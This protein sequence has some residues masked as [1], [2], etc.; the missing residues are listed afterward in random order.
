MIPRFSSIKDPQRVRDLR[1]EASAAKSNAF[2]QSLGE[3]TTKS[4]VVKRMS[5]EAGKATGGATLSILAYLADKPKEEY[6]FGDVTKRVIRSATGGSREKTNKP[7]L[8]A[9]L[10]AASPD[11]PAQAVHAANVKV[12]LASPDMPAFT[13][14]ADGGGPDP[15]L[16]PVYVVGGEGAG[17]D[18]KGEWL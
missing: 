7:K 18:G 6:R 5:V 3:I 10:A 2:F 17:A 14:L 1:D 11:T 13:Q 9:P 15:T 16:D 12:A 8:G 4:A